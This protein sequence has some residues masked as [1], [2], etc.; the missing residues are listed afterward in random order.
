MNSKKIKVVKIKVLGQEY[1]VKTSANPIYFQKVSD[2]VNLK[3]KELIS[4]GID[5]ETQQLKIAVLACLNITDEFFSFKYN[6]NKI[7]DNLESKSK[8]VLELIDEKINNHT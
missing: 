7:L 6:Q 1:I 2:Y 3:T 4:T 5:A 8:M